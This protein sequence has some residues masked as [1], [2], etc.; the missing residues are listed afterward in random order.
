MTETRTEMIAAADRRAA[1]EA[2]IVIAADLVTVADLPVAV[3]VTAAAAVQAQLAT[4]AMTE[5]TKYL[6]WSL[7][8]HHQSMGHTTTLTITLACQETFG[9]F[10]AVLYFFI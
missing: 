3:A 5:T 8:W 9:I 10:I 4:A 2:A 6:S 7:K 1:I